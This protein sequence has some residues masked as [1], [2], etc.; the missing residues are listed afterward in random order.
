MS[1]DNII[2]ANII[3]FCSLSLL[4]FLMD[5]IIQVPE[6]RPQA[7]LHFLNKFAHGNYVSNEQGAAAQDYLLTPL[8]APN[9]T[10][11]KMGDD[12]FDMYLDAWTESAMTV[13][14][15]LPVNN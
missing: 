8:L 11:V 12:E 1:N 13:P 14:Y 6:F 2:H 7:A 9:E 5:A 15:V 10:L 4:L 3:M